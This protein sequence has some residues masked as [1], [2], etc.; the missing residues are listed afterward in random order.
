MEAL[1]RDQDQAPDTEL[2]LKEILTEQETRILRLIAKGLSNKEIA[3]RLH[4][5]GETVKSHIK[6]CVQKAW[7][8]QSST[9]AAACGTIEDTVVSYEDR[10][11]CQIEVAFLHQL[12]K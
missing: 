8:Q 3:D 2:S 1:R 7:N 5:T 12:E 6:K 4:I 11:I 9:S 10:H